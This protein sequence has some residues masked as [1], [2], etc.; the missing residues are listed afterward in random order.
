MGDNMNN[1]EINLCNGDK[2]NVDL[3][4]EKYKTNLIDVSVKREKDGGINSITVSVSMKSEKIDGHKGIRLSLKDISFDEFFADVLYSPY[5]CHPEFG[6]KSDGNTIPEKTQALLIKKDEEYTFILPVCDNIYKTFLEGDNNCIYARIFSQ[7]DSLSVCEKQVSVIFGTGKDPYKIISDCFKYAVNKLGNKVL[8]K[9]QRIYPEIFNYLGWCSWDAMHIHI[10]HTEL[11]EKC[12][13]I[14]EKNIPIKWA[15]LDDMW[16]DCTNLDNIPKDYTVEQMIPTMHSSTLNDFVADPIRFP[17]GLDGC[18]SEMKKTLDYIGVWFPCTGYWSGFTIG[19]EGQNKYIKYLTVL[20]NGKCVPNPD[21]DKPYNLYCQMLKYL[22]Y[23]GADF[24]K[25]DNQ[26]CYATIYD[27]TY[28]IGSMAGSLQNG[29]DKSASDI[30]DGKLINCMGMASECSFNRKKTAISR[31]S[32]DFKP[33]DKAWFAKHIMQCSYN[34]LIWGNLTYSDWDMWWTNDEQAEKNSL[35]RAIS[36]GP[37]YISDR[38]GDSVKSILKPICFD[39]GRILR[40]DN[41]CVPICECLTTDCHK[42]GKALS[43]YN[44][45]HGAVCLA[46]FNIYERNE[47]VIAEISLSQFNFNTDIAVVYNWKKKEVNFYKTDETIKISLMDNDDYSYC[48]IFPYNKKPVIIGRTD[49]FLSPAAILNNRNGEVEIYEKGEISI[50]SESNIS[51]VCSG[52]KMENIGSG[53]LHT[54]LVK[55]KNFS[56]IE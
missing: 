21:G 42:Y 32:D 26:S 7:T 27:N 51:C 38:I 8:L 4:S 16:A 52:D 3:T 14:K 10:N 24:V 2:I 17:K 44:M 49:K 35:L 34:S 54:Y 19:K 23:C 20:R 45:S 50:V 36:G 30:F 6:K 37:I 53:V 55:D 25:I 11:I 15:I 56:I 28:G 31:C 43:V 13:E 1:L 9:E 39:D 40:A 22:K 18:I 48:I 29:I 46:S 47:S 12:V 41:S 33:Q 5:W